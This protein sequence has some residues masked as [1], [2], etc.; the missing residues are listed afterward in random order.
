MGVRDIEERL[1]DHVYTISY[2]T[3][4]NSAYRILKQRTCKGTQSRFPGTKVQMAGSEALIQEVD[5]HI[6]KLAIEVQM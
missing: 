5:P 6:T 3:Q 1:Y 2:T 4:L